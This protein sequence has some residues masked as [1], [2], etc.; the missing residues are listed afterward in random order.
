M[1]EG[2]GGKRGEKA[3]AARDE[4][5]GEPNFCPFERA[6]EVQGIPTLREFPVNIS[7]AKTPTCPRTQSGL[8]PKAVLARPFLP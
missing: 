7:L 6:R 4:Q 8:S 5:K 2:V 3:C 1:Q